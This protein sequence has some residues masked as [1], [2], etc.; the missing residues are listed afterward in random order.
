MIGRFFETAFIVTLFVLWCHPPVLAESPPC[1]P[2]NSSGPEVLSTAVLSTTIPITA[3]IGTSLGAQWERINQTTPDAG[4]GNSFQY[5]AGLSVA[6]ETAPFTF[7]ARYA[8]AHGYRGLRHDVSSD[9][10]IPLPRGFTL[11]GVFS[12]SSYDEDGSATLPF[13][14]AFNLIY[15]F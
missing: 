1:A 11:E 6:G 7:N 10:L 5:T 12:L 2:A 9:L 8:F 14:L 15:E 13:L 4:P 3:E